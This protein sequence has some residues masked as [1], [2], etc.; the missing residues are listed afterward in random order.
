MRIPG[1]SRPPTATPRPDIPPIP[2]NWPR[3]F[4]PAWRPLIEWRALM[5][6]S[7]RTPV[8]HDPT[9]SS[10]RQPQPGVGARASTAAGLGGGAALGWGV[11]V[12]PPPI[13]S[14]ATPVPTA[15][16][17]SR[18]RT[19][20]VGHRTHPPEL[21][22]TLSSPDHEITLSRVTAGVPI[23]NNLA[24]L[25]VTPTAIRP[26]EHQAPNAPQPAMTVTGLPPTTRGR[27]VLLPH[28]QTEPTDTRPTHHPAARATGMNHNDSP[29][30]RPT[31]SDGTTRAIT[32]SRQWHDVELA[33]K[34]ARHHFD[35][36]VTANHEDTPFLATMHANHTRK[37]VHEAARV[38]TTLI[39]TLQTTETEIITTSARNTN[40]P[41][42]RQ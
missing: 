8:G 36:W 15:I 33:V 21:I 7:T 10:D 26:A 13:V 9:G 41:T 1:P 27:V 11:P 20:E 28:T 14:P 23:P 34:V 3:T 37:A 40:T 17:D 29:Q 5:R 30:H 22:T 42:Q 12:V 24:T 2:P 4:H 32:A 31:Q 38:I 16:A 18:G 35:R 19:T 6:R 25:G 39:D